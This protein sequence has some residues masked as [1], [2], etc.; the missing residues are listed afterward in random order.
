MKDSRQCTNSPNPN[1]PAPLRLPPPVQLPPLSP[2]PPCTGRP[3]RLD[4][5]KK[6]AKEYV[7]RPEVKAKAEELRRVLRGDANS[8]W[9]SVGGGGGG[10]FPFP[11]QEEA[12]IPPFS[13]FP[14]SSADDADDAT[15]P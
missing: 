2:P 10:I 6:L 8:G 5:L 11:L 15:S 9:P 13:P 1:P 14:A 12:T 4:A 7:E 3:E